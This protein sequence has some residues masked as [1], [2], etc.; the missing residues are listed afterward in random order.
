MIRHTYRICQKEAGFSLVEVLITVL[1]LAIGLLGLAGLQTSGLQLNHSA[2]QRSQATFLA[3][4]ILD[5]MRGSRTNARNGEYDVDY[6]DTPATGTI[7]GDDVN[8]WKQ[9]IAAV[10][11]IGD[12]QICRSNDGVNCVGSGDSFIIEVR[13]DDNRDGNASQ[14]F[15]VV[16]GL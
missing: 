2:Y 9:D 11:P 4:S 13:W 8:D 10:L 5:R 15:R 7:P 3:Y 14:T 1:V 6:G 16:S 12:G